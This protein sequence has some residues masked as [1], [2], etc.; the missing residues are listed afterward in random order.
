[1]DHSQ[2]GLIIGTLPIS[3]NPIILIADKPDGSEMQEYDFTLHYLE[4]K[5]IPGRCFVEKRRKEEKNRIT[6]M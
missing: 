4:G 5:K 6:R 2:I 1:V 3:R